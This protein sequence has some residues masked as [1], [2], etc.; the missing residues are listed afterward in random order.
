MKTFTINNEG[1][2]I[3]HRTRAHGFAIALPDGQGGYVARPGALIGDL[4]A[5]S[6][7]L[8]VEIATQPEA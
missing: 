2:I 6:K 5:A 1:K 8:K 3:M 7:A 4:E